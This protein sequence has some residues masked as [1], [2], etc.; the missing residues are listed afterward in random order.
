MRLEASDA[1]IR[2]TSLSPGIDNI[3]YDV[4]LS[5]RFV[6][7]ARKYIRALV[8]QIA[9]VNVL[10]NVNKKSSGPPEHS[11]FKK[12][13]TELLEASLTH[14]KYTQNI[15]ADLLNRLAK[16]YIAPDAEFPA[17][18]AAGYIA[19]YAVERIGGVGPWVATAH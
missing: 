17:P 16:V 3:H 15:E 19:R 5:P 14:A 4:Y 11:A 8:R 1:E 18:R 12:I 9:N 2:L 10:K 6:E 13:L 7:A